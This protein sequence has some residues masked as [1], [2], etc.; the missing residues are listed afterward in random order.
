MSE[1][2]WYE[3]KEVVNYSEWQALKTPEGLDYYYNTVSGVTTWDKPDELQTDDEL[4]NRGEWVWV[5]DD[6][7]C[8]VPG[9]VKSKGA[10]ITCQ[11]QS[12]FTVNVPGN[13]KLMPLKPASLKRIVADLVLLDDMSTPL[14][15]HNLKVRFEKGDIY[16]NIG[17]ILISCN[18]YQQLGLYTPEKIF[19]YQYRGVKEMPPHV[20]NIAHDAYKG[21]CDFK[22]CHSV[23]ISGESGAGKTEATKQVLNYL[24]SI[25]GSTNGVEQKV[26][27]ANPILE[28]FGNAKTVRNDNSSRFGKYMEVWFDS[29][30]KICGCNTTNYLLEKI[31]VIQQSP[32]ERNF[33]V[34]YQL[35]KAASGPEKTKWGVSARAQD[36]QYLNV[37]GCVDVP[38]INDQGDWSEMKEAM[39]LLNFRPEDQDNVFSTVAAVLSL[40]NI[41]ITGGAT[42]KIPD[43][44]WIGTA[45]KLL[46]VEEKTLE[47]SLTIRELRI[48]GQQTTKVILTDKQASDTRHA[49]AKF[50]YGN[51]FDWI[52]VKVNESMVAGSGK[53]L[54]IGILDI[55]GF[56]IFKQ[57]SFE[58]LCINFTNEM[59]QQ[60]FNNNTFMLEETIYK[61]EGINFKHVDFIDN[62]PV[63]ELITQKDGGIFTMLDEELVVPKGS[64]Q[65]F[66]DKMHK[67]HE[68]TKHYAKDFRN[69]TLFVVKHYAGEVTY[70][71]IG[72]LEKNRDT[73]TDD[74]YEM[75]GSSKREFIR[76]IFPEAST[77]SKKA[78]L[79]KQ[80][81]GQLN[82]LMRELNRTDPHYIRCVKPNATKSPSTFSSRMSLEQLTYSGV[83]EAVA[84]RKQG[85]P[86]RLTHAVF[87]EHYKCLLPDGKKTANPL[88]ACKEIMQIMKL[89]SNN[90]Q[91]GNSQVLYRADEY[92]ALELQRSI[93]VACLE[94]DAELDRL[95]K[96]NIK[97]FTEA[98]KEKYFEKLSRAVEQADEFRLTSEISNR[99]RKLLDDFIE[100]RI[101]DATKKMLQQAHDNVDEALL[102]KALAICD[103]EG[104][105][106]KM[107][108]QCRRLLARIDRISEEV[109]L[110]CY[111]LDEFHVEAV[112]KAGDEIGYSSE[113]LDYLR[114]LYNGPKKDYL[115]AQYDKA[116]ENK[117][118]DRAIRIGVKMKDIQMDDEAGQW[119]NLASYPKLKA[120]HEWA[121]E[122]FFGSKEI[123]TANFLSW[124]PEK[125]HACLCKYDHLKQTDKVKFKMIKNKMVDDYAYI[126][127]YL[128]QRVSKRETGEE[129][130]RQC[131]QSGLE[132]PE[133]RDEIYIHL[134]KNIT[135]N[136]DPKCALG[137]WDLMS[138]CFLTFP[139]S[140]ELENYL[141][142]YIRK[143]GPTGKQ[144]YQH[145]GW[146]RQRVY[147]GQVQ[148]SP[149]L[150]ELTAIEST[151]ESRSRG[152]SEP[153]PPGAPSWQDLLESYHDQAPVNNTFRRSP[154]NLGAA[155]GGG[156]A[157]GGA[158]RGG[159]QAGG[160]QASRGGGQAGGQASRG[161]GQ[162]ARGGK[163]AAAPSGARA[164][165]KKSAWKPV[166][167]ED[168]GESYYWNEETGESTWDMPAEL[169]ATQVF[170]RV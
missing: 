19:E 32:T 72:F 15:L 29:A 8:Y 73:L 141:E 79:A 103:R 2:K 74:L 68:K 76:S 138:L 145:T 144:K 77:A 83:L 24:A 124:Q 82:D 38:S 161:G 39:H 102:R 44:K 45:A 63:L 58:Q 156:A 47:T 9:T 163:A 117:N 110:V 152:F 157:G 142:Y 164:P 158:K 16:T 104:Y 50:I 107:A 109:N 46:Q 6:E 146:L 41:G 150:N 22:K 95:C 135:N 153:L 11:T 60:H 12:G 93:K 30:N 17:T 133:I 100:S 23:I 112:V 88:A 1:R 129:R 66:L 114:G 27:Q 37:S 33:H 136:P 13:T 86:F 113:W 85:Y 99:A 154:S 168:S 106:T 49:L 20:F 108:K 151:L 105:K 69:P 14:I 118:H 62:K 132:I 149:S 81:T 25:A 125:I 26:L 167:D 148:S 54:S 131:V 57:N 35:C 56:E 97:G 139:P 137:C 28:A 98:Q 170:S 160:G 120:A 155:R 65:G 116:V 92:K 159:G 119:S 90:V 111:T 96:E 48:K 91:Y 128:G 134:I 75:L 165:P 122:K 126:M 101:D 7:M 162:A 34:F 52:V 130:A 70:D 3:K 61:N 127:K 94:M 89:T 147:L 51:M 36:Y 43:R 55:F 59:L 40:G 169:K 42:P 78:S 64:D 53:K 121:G 80:F 140:K 31:R 143:S 71:G 115:K 87:A 67:K 21:L 18:P 123:R 4:A 5:P 166:L 10:E 84:I